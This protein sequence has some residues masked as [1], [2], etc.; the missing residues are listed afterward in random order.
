MAV[1]TEAVPL[2]TSWIGGDAR[3]AAACRS[4]RGGKGQRRDRRDHRSDAWQAAARD[5]FRGRPHAA[6]M[7]LCAAEL[8]EGSRFRMDT[9]PF[10]GVGS[11]GH[12]REGL[13]Y[14]LHEL[15]CVKFTGIRFPG[16]ETR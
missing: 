6:V 7:R 1:K 15:S 11:G 5:Q 10:R 13:K 16:R 2:L 4:D 12:G 8:L 9:A 14:A 3:R